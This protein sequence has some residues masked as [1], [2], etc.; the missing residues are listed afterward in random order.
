MTA[1][2]PSPLRANDD[3]STDCANCRLRTAGLAA[4][5]VTLTLFAFWPVVSCGF[6]NFDDNQYVSENAIVQRG[7]TGEGIRWAFTTGT[8]ANYHPL[9]WLSLM[10]DRTLWGGGALG[11]HLTN[12]AL[13]AANAV[14]LFLVLRTMT[15]STW[16]PLLV[17]ALF[18]VHPLRVES[19]AWISARKDC[20]AA[21]FGLLAVAAY[22]RY[23][24]RPSAAR[25]GIIAAAFAASLLCKAMFITLPAVLL[26]L[27]GW[28]L[29][30][31][32]SWRAL[33]ME[34]LPLVGVALA[35]SIVTLFAQRAG[36]AVGTVARY[37]LLQRVANAVVAYAGYLTKT[38]VPA[39][40][41]IFYPHPRSVQVGMLVVGVIVLGAVTAL[42]IARRK[43]A[44]WVLVGW[45]WFLGTLVP[46]IG[47]IQVGGHAMA[48]RYTYLPMIGLLIAVAWSLPRLQQVPRASA[49]YAA[50]AIVLVMTLSLMTRREIGHWR[51]SVS[52]WSHAIDA[53]HNN[54]VAHANLAVEQAR[55]GASMEAELHYREAIRI[56]P[57]WSTAH[58]GLGVLLA[59][60][61]DVDGAIEQYEAALA[62][63]PEFALAHRN[64]AN[65]LSSRG[66]SEEALG[67]Y[68]RAVELRPD[69]AK[70]HLLMG[71]ELARRG[72][73][74][75]ARPHLQESARLDPTSRDAH[76]YA[77]VACAEAGDFA[78]AGE[79][80]H[81]VLR[82]APGDAAAQAALD[83]VTASTAGGTGAG[84]AP[85]S[86]S[87]S[88]A[89]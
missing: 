75:A 74:A 61:G 87:A 6:V 10:L 18:A 12:V 66:R 81:A 7:L 68:R 20:L 33:A 27:D 50:C 69:D 2:E 44:P 40:L 22:L 14:L 82:A 48:L 30:R 49:V 65:Q 89:D 67:H 57:D 19:V 88:V 51:D 71:L 70:A 38:L 86:R 76:Y 29:K 77:G 24:A 85:R 11:F 42:A 39:D 28:P 15:G 45:L 16:R 63:R 23:V 8:L 5:L 60:R 54:Y 83:Q 46:M 64:L 32:R 13:H 3:H 47:L 55:L 80:F 52:L 36:S 1:I 79:Y 84:S 58:N 73:V 56:R 37:S 59:S 17:A 26:L 31:E 78:A 53:T 9:T 4:L 25:Y 35:A 43:S 62:A 21:F 41:S 34:K 72:D